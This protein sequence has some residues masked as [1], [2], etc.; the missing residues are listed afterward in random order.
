MEPSSPLLPGPGP[1]AAY[2]RVGSALGHSQVG[3]PQGVEMNRRERYR[4]RADEYW[5]LQQRSFSWWTA[6]I[7]HLWPALVVTAGWISLAG[8]LP[9]DLRGV[10]TLAPFMLAILI[11]LTQAVRMLRQS[12]RRAREEH[13]LG[14]LY[15]RQL[16]SEA[17]REA[18]SPDEL[19]AM[20]VTQDL[21][22]AEAHG[23]EVTVNMGNDGSH[24]RL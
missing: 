21:E 6:G 11:V 7:V 10:W 20:I 15:G 19:Q 5:E 4:L 17:F 24:D 3:G 8:L 16:L 12:E 14:W 1:S 13:M 23:F 2:R 18:N 22:H 9:S